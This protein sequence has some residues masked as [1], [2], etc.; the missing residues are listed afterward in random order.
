MVDE[1]KHCG[2]VSGG[3]CG[4]DSLVF[5]RDKKDKQSACSLTDTKGQFAEEGTAKC[6]DVSQIV[7]PG[8]WKQ[9]PAIVHQSPSA[10]RGQALFVHGRPDRTCQ[11]SIRHLHLREASL[12]T[13][14]RTHW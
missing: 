6:V 3:T 13:G 11:H 14:G 5:V 4:D 9:R 2:E 8:R 10:H 12:D 1:K 7:G